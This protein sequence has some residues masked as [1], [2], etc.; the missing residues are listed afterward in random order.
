MSPGPDRVLLPKVAH[1]A[2]RLPREHVVSRAGLSQLAAPPG[3]G[4]LVLGFDEDRRPLAV[5]LFDGRPTLLAVVGTDNLVRVLAFRAVAVGAAVRIVTGRPQ[6]WQSLVAS[7]GG[8]G[9]LV[10]IVGP[11]AGPM[12]GS[13]ALPV[14]TVLD[15]DFR[16]AA[17]QPSPWGTTLSL[18]AA[19]SDSTAATLRAA[20]LALLERC[21]HTQARRACA[22]LGVEPRH[23]PRLVYAPDDGLVLVAGAAPAF[24]RLAATEIERRLLTG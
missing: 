20:D 5:R 14:L 2:L 1:A 16:A 21:D 9:R 8:Y 11:E 24:F 6:R 19:V 12:G 22:L 18:L 4:G 23:V 3:Q 17:R 10:S 7:L 15:A 13:P